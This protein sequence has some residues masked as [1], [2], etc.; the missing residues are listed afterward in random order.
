MCVGVCVLLMIACV[1]AQVFTFD[2]QSPDVAF[3]TLTCM[4]EDINAD[5]YI[6]ST[7]IPVSCLNQGWRSL[8][9]FDEQGNCSGDVTYARIFVRV[10]VTPLQ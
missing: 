2:V 6:A 9:L 7:T 3:L 4:D 8:K 1:C 5:D 10:T